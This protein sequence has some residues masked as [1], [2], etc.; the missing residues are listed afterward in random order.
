MRHA[1]G[2]IGMWLTINAKVRFVHAVETKAPQH[3]QGQRER[4]P[5]PFAKS[6]SG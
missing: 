1:W 3:G 5:T 4:D 2:A 6:T